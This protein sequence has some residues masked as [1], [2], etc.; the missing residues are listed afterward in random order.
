MLCNPKP[1]VYLRETEIWLSAWFTADYLIM[2]YVAPDRWA[3]VNSWASYADILAIVPVAAYLH[4]DPVGGK[5]VGWLQSA[6][7][8]AQR[9]RHHYPHPNFNLHA[10]S[11][12]RRRGP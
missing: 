2:L 7:H 8:P 10:G 5:V 11:F 3:Y 1:Q 12:E 6:R 9:S 4:A